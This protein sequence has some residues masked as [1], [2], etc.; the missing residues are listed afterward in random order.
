V[1]KN[2]ESNMPKLIAYAVNL[3]GV[4]LAS[5]LL[6]VLRGSL[7]ASPSWNENRTAHAVFVLFGTVGRQW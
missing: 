2:R 1:W 5:Y 7:A 3:H 4:A 6:A